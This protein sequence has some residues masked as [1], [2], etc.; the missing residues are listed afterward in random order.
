MSAPSAASILIELEAAGI[1]IS[2]D[3]TGVTLCGTPSVLTPELRARVI[4]AK[5]GILA[6][7]APRLVA[8]SIKCSD[9]NVPHVAHAPHA[10]QIPA[11]DASASTAPDLSDGGPCGTCGTGADA[12]EVSPPR[13]AALPSMPIIVDFE[14][15]ALVRL[16]EVGGRA[17]ARHP[18]TEVL[19]AVLMLP[20]GTVIEWTPAHPAP[21]A[22]FELVKRGV[23]V[24]AHNAHGFDRHVW[25]Q[26]GWPD[27]T[28][29]DSLPLARLRGLPG[30]LEALA[31]AV[32]DIK[33]DTEGRDVTL[34]AGRLDRS[35][36]FPLVSPATLTAIVKY[37]RV[38]TLIV[39]KAWEK[40]LAPALFIEPDVREL[41]AV[42]NE[43]GFH[44][45][46]R[47]AEAIIRCETELGEEARQSAGVEARLLASPEK[48][49][50]MLASSGVCIA[51]VRRDTL[52]ALLDDP[53]LPDDVGA[54]LS[55]R[56]ASSG[57]AAH[58]L[59]AALKRV[60]EDGR[61]RDTLSYCQAHTG[62][63][64]GRG[65]QPQNLPRGA[66]FKTEADIERAI[67]AV[68]REDL[69]TLHDIAASLDVSVHK[70][71]ASLV[72]ACVCAPPARLLGTVDYAQVE[73]RGLLWMAGDAEALMRF[74]NGVDPYRA[75]AAQLF[76][77]DVD[78]IDGTQRSLGKALVL[79]CGYQMGA[80]RFESYAASYNVDWSSLGITP[81]QAV[82]AWRSA[83]PAVA[84]Y[85]SRLANGIAVREGGLWRHMQ[86]AAERA[87]RGARTA[88]GELVWERRGA[89][90][91]CILPSGRP[92][93]Y[94]N[95]RL[96]HRLTKWGT[97]QWT[98]TYEHRGQR[99][100][101]Y[102]GKLTENITQALCRDVLA[103]ALVRLDRAG[104]SIVLHVH[105][106]VV[107]ELED[108][109][110]LAEMESLMCHMPRWA[111]GLPLTA[112][113]HCGR[114]YRK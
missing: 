92:L 26:L 112:T 63:W 65:F 15:R 39:R 91:V 87:A 11:A 73:A 42:I 79:G 54:I 80:T 114:R 12:S 93:V 32:L 53:D 30:K 110:Q 17:Y 85:P 96:E 36:R 23:P 81:A 57:I 104:I 68:M 16:E 59:R 22:A 1:A 50:R 47:L 56:L 37:C 21:L 27:A 52:L 51:N 44:F 105:D 113:G 89:D 76:G 102:G 70:V 100:A 38:D 94:R 107:A 55:A 7:L 90:V 31:E 95:I 28:W 8:S 49:K 3:G 4:N 72:R 18:G 75:M 98:F 34:A 62:R 6:L 13:C 46:T 9:S 101:T 43:R 67:D 19:C 5:R 78:A 109:S 88:L 48:L 82:E 111:A 61:L 108:E 20:D 103:D 14:T 106:E 77:V 99:V 45:D 10:K 41:D 69:V 2:T 84:G 60:G 71:C 97:K 33:K 40:A 58:K 24:M 74:R 29:I 25:Q 66:N 35:G 64:A 83:H 86:D